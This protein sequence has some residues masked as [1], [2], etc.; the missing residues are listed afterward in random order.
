MKNCMIFLVIFMITGLFNA[1]SQRVV[2]P[3]IFHPDD[4][5]QSPYFRVQS[6]DP[7][8]DRLPLKKTSANVNIAGVIAD[9]TINQV[10]QNTG[11]NTLEAIYVFPASTRSAVYSM[12][13]KIG[14]REIIAVIQERDKARQNYEAAKANGQ[15]ASLLEQERPNVFSMNV[16]NILPGDI[17]EVEMKY[18]ELLIPESAIYKFVFPAVVGP[19]YA[20]DSDRTNP[21]DDNWVSNPYLK[22]GK[23]PNYSFDIEVNISAGLPI[24]SLSSLSHNVTITYQGKNKARIGLKNFEIFQGGKDFILD[25]R[26][27]GDRIESGLILYEGEMENFFL[28]MVQPPRRV[29]REEIPP[30]EFIFIVDVSGSMHGFPLDVSKQLMKNLLNDLRPV[31]KFNVLLFAGCSNLFSKESVTAKKENIANAISF[32]N[33]QSGGGGTELLSA[34]KRAMTLLQTEGYSRSF[35]IATDGYIRVEKETFEFIDR[36]LGKANFFTFGIGSSV[37]RYLIEGMAHVGRG[38]PFV[39]INEKEAEKKAANFRKYVSTPVLTN[40][41]VHFRGFNAYD[42]EPVNVPDLL[43]ERP[44]VLFGKWKGSRTGSIEITGTSGGKKYSKTLKVSPVSTSNKNLAIKYLWAREKIRFLDDYQQVSG[45][46]ND[47]KEKVTALGLKYNLLTKYTSFIALDSEIRNENGQLTTIK[48]PLPLPD[49]VSNYAIGGIVKKSAMFLRSSSGIKGYNPAIQFSGEAMEVEDEMV[50][51][52]D[53]DVLPEFTGGADGLKAFIK[54]NLTISESLKKAGLKGVVFVQ[55]IVDKYGN[56]KEIKVIKG[57]HPDAD[58]EAIRLIK[59]TNRKWKSGTR[60][61]KTVEMRMII[62]VKF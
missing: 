55:F 39:V 19:R 54:K 43:A 32:I 36:N 20:G 45:S 7:E 9:V 34:L 61:G 44:I 42:I 48:Q 59:L 46:D 28:A 40:I 33:R 53:N 14:E 49:G 1:H 16:A 10:Y 23:S 50:F 56:V 57:L 37:N 24:R 35:V 30:R 4:R 15:T 58:H 26:L 12:K 29:L 25:Y 62:P 52:P 41:A 60:N 6:D 27:S 47:I 11:K 5:N 8:T 51:S 13:M 2:S 22:E 17:I 38:K 3:E 31:D 18:T 21:Q